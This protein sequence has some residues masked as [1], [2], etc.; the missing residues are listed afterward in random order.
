MT[1]NRRPGPSCLSSSSQQ[2]HP[3]KYFSVSPRKTGLHIPNIWHQTFR[4]IVY[5]GHFLFHGKSILQTGWYVISHIGLYQID[6]RKRRKKVYQTARP[7]PR[8]TPAFFVPNQFHQSEIISFCRG[9]CQRRHQQ[10]TDTPAPSG[11][12]SHHLLLAG[13]GSNCPGEREKESEE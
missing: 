11:Y 7:P 10:V 3:S 6:S 8:L 5:T 9:R 13:L 4:R 2:S 1:L 12:I